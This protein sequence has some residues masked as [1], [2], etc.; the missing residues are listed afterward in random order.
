M[1]TLYIYIPYLVFGMRGVRTLPR[2]SIQGQHNQG[3]Q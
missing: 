3:S 1:V 2:I